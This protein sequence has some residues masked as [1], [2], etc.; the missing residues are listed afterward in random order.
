MRILRLFLRSS[1]FLAAFDAQR[2]RGSV[3]DFALL[4]QNGTF[5]QASYY[6]DHDA[7]VILAESSETLAGE[8]ARTAVSNIE[9]VEQSGKI[10]AFVISPNSGVERDALQAAVSALSTNL[11]VLIDETQLVSQSLI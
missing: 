3:G 11:P 5:H 1:V 10:K 6:S 9:S 2:R 4:D 8:R 7:I